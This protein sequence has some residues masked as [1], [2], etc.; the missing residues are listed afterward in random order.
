MNLFRK[1]FQ[2][3]IYS[4]LHVSIAVAC[5]TL[6]SG[7]L[8]TTDVTIEACFLACATFIAYHFIRYMNRLKYGKKHLLDSFSNQYKNEIVTM[9]VL[10]L[11]AIIVLTFY[12]QKAQIFRLIPFGGLTLMYGVSFLTIKQKKYS[13][14]YVPGLKIFIIAATWA[15]V[16]VFFIKDYSWQSFNYFLQLI[17]LVI[18]LTLPF[19]I[20]DVMFDKG[21]VKTIPMVLGIKNSKY[22]GT[23]LLLCFLGIHYYNFK[24]LHF[25]EMLLTAIVLLFLLWKSKLK[26]STYYASFWVEG[27]PIF[28]YLLMR[29]I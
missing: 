8:F 15:G 29:L 1:I 10:T 27:I 26:Q 17:C 23:F 19:D 13:L 9:L 14:R 20:R 6:I 5:L 12:I 24:T 28:C 22:L 21:S 11:F 2:F 25:V 16:V 18:V 7:V 3:Y 4:N